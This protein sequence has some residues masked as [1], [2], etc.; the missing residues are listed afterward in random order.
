MTE[1]SRQ[2]FAEEANDGLVWSGRVMKETATASRQHWVTEVAIESTHQLE[3]ETEQ[4]SA[5]PTELSTLSSWA[6]LEHI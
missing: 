4:L 2:L 6:E 3:T 1:E 5:P